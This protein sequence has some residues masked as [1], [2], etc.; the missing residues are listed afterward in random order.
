[1][2]LKK[3]GFKGKFHTV[4]KT[5]L[6]QFAREGMVFSRI[7]FYLNN[8]EPKFDNLIYCVFSGIKNV[9]NDKTQVGN[10]SN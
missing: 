4:A 10:C 2:L 6:I 3:I 1:M 7:I 5:G 9:V 8:S